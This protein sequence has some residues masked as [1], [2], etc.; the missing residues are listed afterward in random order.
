MNADLAITYGAVGVIFSV[1]TVFFLAY[2]WI[3]GRIS[4]VREDTDARTDALAT[5]IDVLLRERQQLE[6]EI[7]K[8]Y[9]TTE[10]VNA[11]V[12][13]VETAID[14]LINRFDEFGVA[15]QQALITLSKET[16]R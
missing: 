11:A 4:E 5:K 6:L 12:S 16:G 13:R 2:R 9:A 15:F 8:R 10:S 14:K 1:V 7:V 3:D